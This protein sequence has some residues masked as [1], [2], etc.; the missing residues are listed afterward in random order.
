MPEERF[1]KVLTEIQ[2][3][4]ALGSRSQINDPRLTGGVSGAY[5]PFV[6]TW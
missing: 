1:G 2:R 5:R 6:S 4:I 3:M